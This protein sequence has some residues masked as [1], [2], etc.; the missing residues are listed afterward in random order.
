MKENKYNKI[1]Y[2]IISLLLIS[3]N[4]S[5]VKDIDGNLYNAVKIGNQIWMAE[6]LNVDH[7]R[8][9][10]PIPEINDTK[11]W[12]NLEYGAWCYYNNDPDNGKK[13]GRLYNWYA[14]NDYRGLAP[15]GWHI[16]TQEDY[17]NLKRKVNSD[18]NALLSVG[19]INGEKVGNNSSGFSALFGGDRSYHGD[20]HLDNSISFWS[21][22][23]SGGTSAYFMYLGPGITYENSH[24]NVINRSMQNGAYV[25]CIKNSEVKTENHSVNEKKIE[26]GK[27]K[28]LEN[29]QI[30]YA[31]KIYH[32][33][34]IG[35]QTWLKENLDV[36]T[37]I[38]GNQDQS[39]NGTIEKYCFDDDPANCATYGGL[40][41]WNEAMQYSVVEGSKGICP[42]GW[43]MPTYGEFQ[44]LIK[45]VNDDGNSLKAVGQGN[46]EGIGINTSEFT[47]LL[48]SYRRPDGSFGQLGDNTFFWRSQENRILLY[49]NV[50]LRLY[51]LGRG[52]DFFNFSDYLLP[53]GFSV[54][55]VKD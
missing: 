22:S 48:A 28:E 12:K 6:N 11:E 25:R 39:N 27:A 44:T 31:G 53:F 8:N 13:Y 54:R 4:K 15:D 41:Q 20:F 23:H 18:E 1:I 34:K 33:I 14:V 26:M 30:S 17:E 42:D 19:V 16:P 55:C 9:G 24:I 45:S 46:G 52:M 32:T 36:G 29:K 50:A 47:A 3:C 21:A 7:Y 35:S 38:K 51:Q 10:D 5:E 37:M 43:H 49:T 40:Y 2:L